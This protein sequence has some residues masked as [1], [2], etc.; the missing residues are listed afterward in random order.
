ME[1]RTFNNAR[2]VLALAT[3]LLFGSTA[4]A[5]AAGASAPS[6]GSAIEAVADLAPSATAP[7]ASLSDAATPQ[8]AMAVPDPRAAGGDDAV[9][10][11]VSGPAQA[12]AAVGEPTSGVAGAGSRASIGE[13]STPDPGGLAQAVQ[14]AVAQARSTQPPSSSGAAQETLAAESTAT[15][16]LAWQVQISPCTSRCIGTHQWQVAEQQNTTLQVGGHEGAGRN[17]TLGGA[18]ASVGSSEVRQIQIGC[19]AHCFGTTTTT[20]DPSIAGYRDALERILRELATGLAGLGSRPA[21]ATNTVQQSSYQSQSGAAEASAQSQ[22]V[23]QVG[24]SA[25]LLDAG[26][27]AVR[28]Q[29]REVFN[30]TTQGI[31]QLQIGCLIFCHQTTQYQQAEQDNR[32]TQTASASAPVAGGSVAAAANVTAQLIWQA[33]VGCMFWCYDASEQQIASSHNVYTGIAGRRPVAPASEEPTVSVP[34]ASGAAIG[35]ASPQRGSPPSGAGALPIALAVPEP[36]TAATPAIRLVDDQLSSRGTRTGRPHAS[37]WRPAAAVAVVVL[38][39][40]PAARPRRA[41]A[42][43]PAASTRSLSLLGTTGPGAGGASGS[44]LAGVAVAAAVA[45]FGL[46]LV[47][48]AFLR[49]AWRPPAASRE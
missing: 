40:R 20:T 45:L 29:S 46:C 34:A 5:R 16:Q 48:V 33:Q 44:N 21:I 47:C 24:D 13:A 12:V 11:S 35:S 6:A 9:P 43:T 2:L 19:L 49:T 27:E 22:G 25:Q 8:R 10:S 26:A 39:A 14:E 15:S 32:T 3:A 28:G 36:G 4:A 18:G 37:A 1:T 17:G 7:A 42:G 23:S 30:Q 31:W 41:A 38:S